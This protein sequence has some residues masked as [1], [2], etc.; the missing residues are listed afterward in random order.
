[1]TTTPPP[2]ARYYVD[3]AGLCNNEVVL[4]RDYDLLAA[5]CE[6]LRKALEEIRDCEDHQ[7]FPTDDAEELRCLAKDALAPTSQETEK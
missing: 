7:G 4:A 1:M 5:E 3:V 6:R 2:V